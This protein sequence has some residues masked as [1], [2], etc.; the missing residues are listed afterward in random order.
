[1]VGRRT[2]RITLHGMRSTLRFRAARGVLRLGI[3]AILPIRA[4]GLESVPRGPYLVSCNHLNW[5]D[6]FVLIAALPGR[7]SLHF[8]GRGSAI[9]NRLWKRWILYL[10]GDIVIPVETGEIAHLSDAVGRALR[11]GQAVG[12]FPE[13]H[14]GP[15]E[16]ELQPLRKGV[17][18]FAAE[19]SVPVVPAALSGTHELSAGKTHPARA[20]ASDPPERGPGRRPGR[21]RAGDASGPAGVQGSPGAEAL[22]LAHDTPQVSGHRRPAALRRSA[23]R[24][25]GRS[26]RGAW[27]GPEHP[28]ARPRG[29]AR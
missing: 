27:A 11:D 19:G 21:H 14:L 25:R 18:H 12:I 26:A 4:A 15:A 2:H 17:A 22:A 3:A 16:G 29:S 28:A 10:L 6:P 23:R 24:E 7:P 9:H 8:L 1:M 13:G 5:V 20:G